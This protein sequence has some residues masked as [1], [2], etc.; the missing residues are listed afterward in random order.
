MRSRNGVAKDREGIELQLRTMATLY[1][2]QSA[3]TKSNE[4]Y[5][6]ADALY[7]SYMETFPDGK[8]AY[9]MGFYYAELLMTLKKWE[10]AAG[11]YERIL[12]QKPKG[13]YSAD[14][15]SSL[16]VAYKTLL[17]VKEP[18]KGKSNTPIE[19]KADSDDLVVP[20]AKRRSQAITPIPD[21][22]AETIWNMCVAKIWRQTS[23]T[24]SPR[25][26]TTLTNSIKQ[27]R[28]SRPLRRANRKSSGGLL[29]QLA[30]GYP[31]PAKQVRRT[32]SSKP[33]PSDIVSREAPELF[34]RL[35]RIK[36]KAN[37]NTCKEVS[38]RGDQ[39]KAAKCYL[40][41]AQ[42][43][44][45]SEFLAEAYLNAAVE[46]QKQRLIMVVSALLKVVNDTD[47]PVL[48]EKALFTIGQ[49]FEKLAIFSK[50]SGT[51][52]LSR[53]VPGLRKSTYSNAGCSD[54]PYGL[55]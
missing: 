51:Y 45:E 46:Y 2:R 36:Q 1:H 21:G 24:I 34:S 52:E 12:A 47:D 27:S 33:K 30:L 41:F 53:R 13:E 31:C 20:K 16:V 15:A 38:G 32:Q 42:E 26:I 50:A 10:E 29:G 5:A 37:F 44:P 14:A 6:V 19:Q 11:H 25:P 40:R 28:D 18:S 43:F 22:V 17:A 9:E 39:A 48:R 3:T 4:D 8:H 35:I 55:G 54:L 49:N 7:S 23:P